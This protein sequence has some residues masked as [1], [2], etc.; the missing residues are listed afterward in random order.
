VESILATLARALPASAASSAALVREQHVLVRIARQF[1]VGEESLRQRLK[2]LRQAAASAERGSRRTPGDIAAAKPAAA[3]ATRRDRELIE[4]VLHH[5]EMLDELLEHIGEADIESPLVQQLFVVVLDLHH[6]GEAPSFDRL[7]N[8][9][10]DEQA[11]YLLVDCDEQG[12]PKVGCDARQRVR[13]L[14]EYFRRRRQDAG[15]QAT[16]AQLKQNQLDPEQEQ[17]ALASL[18]DD[19][20]RRQALFPPTDG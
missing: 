15:H 6:A 19:L 8:A 16:L 9:V 5:P 20:K 1:G 12:L 18:F 11:K 13:D 10:D 4:I 3:P 17:L 14:I 7:M 2:A